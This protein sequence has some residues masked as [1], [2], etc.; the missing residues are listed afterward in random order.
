M[1]FRRVGA[2]AF[3]RLEDPTFR[4]LALFGDCGAFTYSREK[5]PPYT[6]DDMLAFYEDGGF[7]YGCLVD[8]IIFDFEPILNGMEGGSKEARRR[9]EITLSNAEAF[10]KASHGLVFK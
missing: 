10:L 9:F 7:D 6:P 8:H 4:R 3:L 5:E 2:R 1:R